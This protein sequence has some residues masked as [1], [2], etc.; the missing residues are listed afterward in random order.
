MKW[1][2]LAMIL[3][4]FLIILPTILCKL[5]C[6]RGKNIS[7]W[8]CVLTVFIC[9]AILYMMS[10]ISEVLTSLLG[11]AQASD[12]NMAI[13][14]LIFIPVYIIL[15]VLIMKK[16]L[17]VGV[18]RGIIVSLIFLVCAILGG[19]ITTSIMISDIKKTPAFKAYSEQK[20]TI[21]GLAD[22]ND[23]QPFY[24]KGIKELQQERWSTA[25]SFFQ[26]ATAKNPRFA[27]AW[28]Q[29]GYCCG[30]LGRWQ[31]S[32]KAFKQ[33]IILKPD[34]A[35]AH[36]GLGVVYLAIGDKG[37]ALDEYKILKTSDAERA[38]KLFNLIYK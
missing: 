25:L 28:F 26:Q 34:L 22:T 10:K 35:A 12:Q 8:W 33:A 13:N 21:S 15:S 38:N 11:I 16:I 7:V 3:F 32:I 36:Y 18:I 37:S 4:F 6:T 1:V 23:A 2:L 9:F 27:D 29:V 14:L 31:E 19:G 20:G 30:N 24:D 17:T 5:I